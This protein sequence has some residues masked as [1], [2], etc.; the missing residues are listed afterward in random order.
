MWGP[1]EFL[2]YVSR[3]FLVHKKWQ[4]CLEAYPGF[5]FTLEAGFIGKA[6]V[7]KL[8]RQRQMS[9]SVSSGGIPGT[10][11]AILHPILQTHEQLWPSFF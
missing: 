7:G 5:I 1:F 3:E 8:S 6:S 10:V 4:V 11:T 9:E 2:Y